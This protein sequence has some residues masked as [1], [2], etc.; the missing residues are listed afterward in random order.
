MT[1]PYNQAIPFIVLAIVGA[2]FIAEAAYDVDIDL[3]S[4]VP[5]LAPLGVAG[6]AKAAIENAGSI[7]KALPDNIPT[8][9]I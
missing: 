4:L 2:T 7:R 3:E 6:A 5:I 8:P 1:Q 9:D